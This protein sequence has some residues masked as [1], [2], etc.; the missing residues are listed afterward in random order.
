MKSQPAQTSKK[1]R[2]QRAR[3]PWNQRNRK[4]RRER[5]RKMQSEDLRLEGVHP[6][7]AGI[8]IGNEVHYGAVPSN[9]SS[10]PVR[11]FACT[12]AE[13]QAI[14]DWLKQCGIRTIAMQSTGVYW[15]AVLGY[16]SHCTSL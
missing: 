7:A 1:A 5:Q 4:Q 3:K 16:A 13:L 2:P 11:R 15:I 14:P 10:E 6:A 9:R 12:T 8:D